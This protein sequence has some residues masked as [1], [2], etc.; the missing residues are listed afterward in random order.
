MW[1]DMNTLLG[2]LGWHDN[3]QL[4]FPVYEKLVWEFFSSFTIDT[5]G[6]YHNG[7]CYIHFRLGDPTDEMN[8]ARF[9]KLLQFQPSG[10]TDFV[11]RDYGRSELWGKITRHWQPCVSRP[12]KATSISNLILRCL[13]RLTA[14]NIF[15]RF[16]SQGALRRGELFILWTALHSVCPYTA[17]HF[18]TQLE[19]HTKSRT[20][21]IIVGGIVI[22]LA[23]GLGLGNLF[24]LMPILRDDA[25][26]NLEACVH[27][28]IFTI[29]GNQIWANHHGHA[30]F[31]LPDTPYHHH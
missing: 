25:R 18:L 3:V 23:H 8:L 28:E 10:T 7:H 12:S 20:S 4:Q 11:H 16:D 13:Q 5:A 19:D 17:F 27:V 21:V 6:E 31:R 26:L 2:H 24:P 29:M 30:L 22:A 14:N 15:P 1:E 9:S